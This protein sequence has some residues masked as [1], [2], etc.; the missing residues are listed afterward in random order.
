M[1]NVYI[2]YPTHAF[3]IGF[4]ES[5]CQTWSCTVA[6]IT[7]NLVDTYNIHY[8]TEKKTCRCHSTCPQLPWKIVKVNIHT[9]H[10]A[11]ITATCVLLTLSHR[12][13]C[14]C[15]SVCALVTT[16]NPK[17][18]LY[19]TC[20]APFLVLTITCSIRN[21]VNSILTMITIHVSTFHFRKLAA[22]PVC[23]STLLFFFFTCHWV[24]V[25]VLS[26]ACS[27]IDSAFIIYYSIHITSCQ[28]FI[29]R[30]WGGNLPLP[31]KQY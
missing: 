28:G 31:H 8:Q 3:D 27:S 7:H 30:V 11:L 17:Q 12:S 9:L 26:A 1:L 21:C 23:C 5:T 20:V 29:Q 10:S 25:K 16:S 6:Y 13:D 14:C 4:G 15:H 18:Q 24:F 22:Y 2:T 19:I